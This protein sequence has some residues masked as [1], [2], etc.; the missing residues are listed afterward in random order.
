[1]N[2]LHNKWTLWYHA[3]TSQD[4]TV[5]GYNK[6]CD[7]ESVEDF[8]NI[9]ERLNINII[10]N[11]MFFLMKKDVLP[12]WEDEKNIN[13][14]CWSYKIS[15]KDSF[16]SWLEISMAVCGEY[17]LK[18]QNTNIINGI[19]ISPKRNFCIIK[20]WNNDSKIND[21]KLLSK[22]YNLQINN[23]LYK[24]HCERS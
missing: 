11:G 3:L 14:G 17:L 20:I 23:C 24:A 18:G 2:L 4:W 8:W 16:T 1:M 19:S 10:Q 6:I 9:N 13:G 12:L 15:K 22:V 21:P 7:I 5:K